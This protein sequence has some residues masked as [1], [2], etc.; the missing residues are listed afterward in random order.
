MRSASRLVARRTVLAALT[1]AAGLSCRTA[2]VDVRPPILQPGA[3]GDASRAITTETAVDLRHV[4][5]T[6]ADTQFMQ[7]MIGHHQQAV[8][9]T[10]LLATRTK[11]EAMRRL[12]QRIAISQ[13]DEIRLMQRWLT[14]RGEAGADA[15]ARHVHDAALMPGMLTSEEM[16]R[17]AAAT[18]PA[19]DRLFL[20]GMIKHHGGALTMVEELFTHAGAGQ[21]S[22]VFMFVSDVDAD[23]RAEIARMGALLEELQP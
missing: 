19:F 16:A 15:H 22:E 7:A 5:A 4:Q 13:A 12:G 6:A 17:L 23:Q 2:G 3:P 8:D 1:A 14:V 18:G 20:E 10:A 11:S 9:M 21:E